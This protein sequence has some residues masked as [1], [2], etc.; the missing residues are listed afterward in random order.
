M[1]N[2]IEIFH[3]NVIKNKM[4]IQFLNVCKIDYFLFIPENLSNNK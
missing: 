4:K 2:K 3:R 1:K